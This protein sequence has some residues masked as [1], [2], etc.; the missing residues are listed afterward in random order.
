MGW[1]QVRRESSRSS[2]QREGWEKSQQSILLETE[3]SRVGAG[4]L[5]R[6][7]RR[8]VLL[9]T[10]RIKREKCGPGV[11]VRGEH[12]PHKVALGLGTLKFV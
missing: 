5:N 12:S 9:Q 11:E 4:L 10:R 3:P 1:Q 2:H 8:K 7:W 6:E